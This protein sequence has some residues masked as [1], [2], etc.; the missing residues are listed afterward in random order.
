MLA[1]L[2]DHASGLAADERNSESS[3]YKTRSAPDSAYSLSVLEGFLSAERTLINSSRMRSA[4]SDGKSRTDSQSA[5][6]VSCS[7]FKAKRPAKRKARK[8]R[9]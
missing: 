4:E 3:G 2:S 5:D 7:I 6:H 1:N 8:T 9:R